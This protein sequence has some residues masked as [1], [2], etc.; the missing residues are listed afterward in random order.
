MALSTF[1]FNLSN[2]NLR[3]EVLDGKEYLVAPMAMLTVGVHNGSQGPLMYTE[4]ELSKAPSVWNMK[5]IVVYHPERDGKGI[6]ACDQVIINN[7]GIGLV[8]NA[9]F[10]GKLRAEAWLDVNKMKQVDE[11]VLVAVLNNQMMEV[12]TGLFRDE[13]STPGKFGGKQFVGH[14]R[15]IKP[16]H[17]AILPDKI[18]ACSIA[19]GAG[20]LQLNELVENAERYAINAERQLETAFRQALRRSGL[21]DNQMSHGNIRSALAMAVRERYTDETWIE[22]VYDDFIIVEN[23]GDLLRVDYSAE[24]TAVT[25]SSEQPEKVVRVTEYR[26]VDGA[27]VGNSTNDPPNPKEKDMGKEQLVEDLIANE[28]TKWTEDHREFLM[29]TD[30]SLLDN[31]IPVVKN[32][33]TEPSKK[34]EETV[35]DSPANNNEPTGQEEPKVVSLNEYIEGAPVELQD[36]LRN[37]IEA[38]QNEKEALIAKITANKKNKFAADTL[39]NMAIADL[40]NLALLAEDEEEGGQGRPNYAGQAGSTPAANQQDSS[41]PGAIVDNEEP[42]KMP[43]LT[44]GS[45]S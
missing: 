40:R 43:E 32:D 9:K 4:A 26:T 2:A 23:D 5:P 16:D 28:G 21:V 22:D 7:R 24:E 45:K 36:V 18:G 37:G 35:E 3:Y 1:T 20:L 33:S 10:D 27:F 14:A 42:L 13:D 17:L 19:D 8:M 25:L 34:P 31:F 6:S 41:M 30:E 11:R 44:F 15:N 12:S 39:Q 29:E 38:H